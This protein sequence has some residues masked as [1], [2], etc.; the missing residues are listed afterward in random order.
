RNALRMVDNSGNV[1]DVF[2]QAVGTGDGT[3]AKDVRFGVISTFDR[4]PLGKV[5]I[6][7]SSAFKI[8]EFEEGG[9][10]ETLIGNGSGG[11]TGVG[12]TRPS[13]SESLP[14][15]GTAYEVS[16]VSYIGEDDVV[17]NS[18]LTRLAVWNRTNGY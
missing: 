11:N 4:S 6:Y 7:E 5:A 17:F 8:R 18:H 15:H 13:K 1:Q 16:Y 9:S 12:A 3:L 14:L 2:G 10:V